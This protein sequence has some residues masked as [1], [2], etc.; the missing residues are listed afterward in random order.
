MQVR[1][2]LAI[3]WI[4]IP[5][6]D[7]QRGG[8]HATK[9]ARMRGF[10]LPLSDNDDGLFHEVRCDLRNASPP[11]SETHSLEP[12]SDGNVIRAGWFRL[13]QVERTLA[14]IGPNVW[15]SK[16]AF[17][18]PTGSWGRVIWNDKAGNAEER[19]LVEHIVNAGWFGAPPKTNI[20]RGLPA[21]ERD[22]RRDFLRTGYAA[23]T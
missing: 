21:V 12:R 8:K 10:P 15:S 1:S 14:F 3:Q 16:P 9:R 5:Y 7:D 11:V 23:R 6:T 2:Y 17:V 20:F 18:V 13:A 4:A 22:M 19:W